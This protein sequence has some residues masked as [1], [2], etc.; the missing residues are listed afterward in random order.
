MDLFS[1]LVGGLGRRGRES[2]SKS[3][4]LSSLKYTLGDGYCKEQVAGLTTHCTALCMTVYTRFNT[5]TCRKEPDSVHEPGSCVN[6]VGRDCD[7]QARR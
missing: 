3:L 7:K 2:W 5:L 4:K 1:S 6:S